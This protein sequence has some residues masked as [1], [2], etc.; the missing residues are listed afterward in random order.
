MKRYL[1]ITLLLL[2]LAFSVIGDAKPSKKQPTAAAPSGKIKLP[3]PVTLNSI[4]DRPDTGCGGSLDPNLNKQKNL[5]P[6][7]ST[8]ED[9]DYS[10][11]RGLPDPVLNFAIG[12]AREKPAAQ[13]EGKMI[14]V[15][16]YAL[17]ARKGGKESRNCGL[18]KAADTDNHIVLVDLTLPNPSLGLL[19][20][21]VVGS[22]TSGRSGHITSSQGADLLTTVNHRNRIDREMFCATAA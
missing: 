12:D 9:K 14:R 10:Y 11:L 18:T 1:T 13:G 7:S 22:K 17:V 16:A 3:C 5:V 21:S 4:T 8:P 20:S 2:V 19:R 15:V 6:G